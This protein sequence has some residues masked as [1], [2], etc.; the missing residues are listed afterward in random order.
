MV[1]NNG[2]NLSTDYFIAYLNLVMKA[3]QCSVVCAKKD[4]LK[5][6]PHHFGP[7]SYQ[8]FAQA[9]DEIEINR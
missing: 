8:S 5:G 3:K 4:I 2:E 6:N 7:V 9:L 1:L